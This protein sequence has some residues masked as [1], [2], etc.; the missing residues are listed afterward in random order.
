MASRARG[1]GEPAKTSS[2]SASVLNP[3]DQARP[4]T[5]GTGENACAKCRGTGR[6]SG[7]R[8]DQCGGTGR[9]IEG[10]GGG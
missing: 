1:K 4:G 5:I 3:G 2:D 9:I 8:C 6:V 10:I 7:E